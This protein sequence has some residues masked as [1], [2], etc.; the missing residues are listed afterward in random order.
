MCGRGPSAAF[1][2]CAVLALAVGTTRQR[3]AQTLSILHNLAGS[4]GVGQFP[5]A[6]LIRDANGDF[7]GTALEGGIFNLGTVFKMANDSFPF[8][9][10]W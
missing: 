9:R 8:R 6:G 1:A 10:H 7:Y 5:R 2:L 4:N 3:Q